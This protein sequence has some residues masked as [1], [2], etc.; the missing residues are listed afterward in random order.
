MQFQQ[1]GKKI[2]KRIKKENKTQELLWGYIPQ[3]LFCHHVIYNILHFLK[4]PCHQQHGS[5]HSAP[6]L[7]YYLLYQY[8][9]LALESTFLTKSY[10]KNRQ[11]AK[12]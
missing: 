8:M 5:V 4:V 1:L 12:E 11:K 7:Q 2:I 9:L 6:E 10:L 3:N